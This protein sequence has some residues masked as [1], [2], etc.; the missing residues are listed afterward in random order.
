M[1]SIPYLFENFKLT[2]GEV[3]LLVEDEVRLI[4]SYIPCTFDL[5]WLFSRKTRFLTL[6]MPV[7]LM[8]Y[9]PPHFL[10]KLQDS[11]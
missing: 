3:Y 4:P 1:L 10:I 8:Y 2:N 5:F 7:I 6:I 11:S 9:S